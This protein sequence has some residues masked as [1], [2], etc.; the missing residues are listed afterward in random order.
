MCYVCP[1]VVAEPNLLSAPL[2]AVALFAG[3]GQFVPCVNGLVWGHLEP[4]L[5]QT[6]CLPEMQ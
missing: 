1:A 5:N 6:M 4:E 2:P 3:C